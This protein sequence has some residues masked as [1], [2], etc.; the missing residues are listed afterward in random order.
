M[1]FQKKDSS[2]EKL[3]PSE[4]AEVIRTRESLLDDL[5]A[6][7]RSRSVFSPKELENYRKHTEKLR[8]MS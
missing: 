7:P 8:R 4:K 5:E 3:S 1:F 6:D 2:F